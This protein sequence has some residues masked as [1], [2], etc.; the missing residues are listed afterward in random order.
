MLCKFLVLARRDKDRHVRQADNFSLY[1]SGFADRQA[2]IQ[3][4]W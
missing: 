2:D 3:L 1:A 4:E